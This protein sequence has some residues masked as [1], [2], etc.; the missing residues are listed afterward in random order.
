MLP[1]RYISQLSLLKSFENLPFNIFLLIFNNYLKY[2]KREQHA[3]VC[4]L[5]KLERNCQ[6]KNVGKVPPD[7]FVLAEN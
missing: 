4:L 1:A 5:G 3:F 2:E 7:N 6:V